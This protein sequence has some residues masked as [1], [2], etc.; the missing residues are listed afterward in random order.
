[1]MN[2]GLSN[3]F[4]PASTVGSLMSPRSPSSQ[5]Q[6]TMTTSGNVVKRNSRF[7]FSRRKVD[8]EQ[9]YAFGNDDDGGGERRIL[10]GKAVSDGRTTVHPSMNIAADIVRRAAQKLEV[11]SIAEEEMPIPRYSHKDENNNA[12]GSPPKSRKSA[13]IMPSG[14]AASSGRFGRPAVPSDLAGFDYR[15]L[16]QQSVVGGGGGMSATTATTEST[17]DASISGFSVGSQSPVPTLSRSKR[18]DTSTVSSS[19]RSRRFMFLKKKKE[20]KS[21]SPPRKGAKPQPLSVIPQDQEFQSVYDPFG[22]D[23]DYYVDN[24]SSNNN[25][26]TNVIAQKGVF[27]SLNSTTVQVK[28][29]E[30]EEVED[31]PPTPKEVVDEY[32]K[33]S[34]SYE[35]EGKES[36]YASVPESNASTAPES[37]AEPEPEVRRNLDVSLALNEDLT[38]EYKKSKLSTLTVEGTIQVRISTSYE[39][40]APQEVPPS[41]PFI[42]SFKD[43]SGHV[44]TLQENKKFVENVSQET[45]VANREFTYTITFPR[46]EEYFP[47]LRYKCDTSLRPVPIVSIVDTV[48]F[49]VECFFTLSHPAP[50]PQPRPQPFLH[51][52]ACSNSSSYPRDAL[53]CRPSDK[54]QPSKSIRSCSSHYNHGRSTGLKGRNS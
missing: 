52:S 37:V 44:R 35:S 48:P 7:T 42:L 14:A 41:I 51:I 34:L 46:E 54:F 33:Q 4:S 40:D 27:Q 43:H 2:M 16:V 1:M 10:D 26:A 19:N 36:S 28:E 38:C 15:P 39:G 30:E 9:D 50:P 23:D 5:N 13:R 31:P 21:S 8:A 17:E 11:L 45:A 49:F 3:P 22:T 24:S 32:L 53:P 18:D 20:E 12:G 6:N 29:E 25:H 47:V